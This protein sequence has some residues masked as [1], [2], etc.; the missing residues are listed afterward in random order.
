MGR[1]EFLDETAYVLSLGGVESVD[2]GS[3]ALNAA[4]ANVELDN[5]TR[6]YDPDNATGPLYSSLTH[7]GQKAYIRLGYNGVLV[8]SPQ[9]QLLGRIRLPEACA[10]VCFDHEG[11]R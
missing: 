9:G 1:R 11:V 10:N 3:R 7:P 8:F 2:P 4:E 6:R 5:A